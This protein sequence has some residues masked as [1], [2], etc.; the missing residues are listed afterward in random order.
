MAGSLARLWIL[1]STLTTNMTGKIGE[2]A[3]CNSAVAIVAATIYFA[4]GFPASFT[5]RSRVLYCNPGRKPA[6][7]AGRLPLL[8]RHVLNCPLTEHL[9]LTTDCWC[10]QPVVEGNL[11]SVEGEVWEPTKAS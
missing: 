6:V 10:S 1:H 4:A 3:R 9:V 5:G 2:M 8:F 7:P 11:F